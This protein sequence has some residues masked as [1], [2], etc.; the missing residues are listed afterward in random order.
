MIR[1]K[2]D[3]AI[4]AAVLVFFLVI[5]FIYLVPYF[6]LISTS[7]KTRVDAFSIPPKIVHNPT[8]ENYETVFVEKDFLLN[9]RNSI[10]VT[11]SVTLISMSAGL[12]SAYAFSRF[13]MKGDKILF[14]YLLGTRF[15][16]VIVLALPLYFIMTDVKLLNT[17]TGIIVAHSAFNVA[18]VTWMMKGFFDAVP[19]EIDESA[20]VDGCSWLGIFFRIGLPLTSQ[21]IAATSVFCA[22]NSWNEFLMA[23]ILTGHRTATLPV[24]I[25][26][27]MTPQGTFWGQIAAVGSVITVPVL[28]FSFI[29]QK[30]MIQGMSTGAIK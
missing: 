18:L 10:I 6:W 21:G 12:P 26:G 20:R 8:L 11:F 27:L 2:K 24:A 5:I 15:T 7:F 29:V 13:R 30:Y 23:L 9:L 25:P 28:I 4:K 14:F 17:F 16:P 3:K 19:K 22:I 1:S